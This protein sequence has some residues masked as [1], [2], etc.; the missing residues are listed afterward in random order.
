MPSVLLGFLSLKLTHRMTELR[1]VL[2][3]III[4]TILGAVQ[5]FDNVSHSWLQ[6]VVR[7]IIQIGTTRLMSV[8]CYTAMSKIV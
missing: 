2:A 5:R 4:F 6:R 7:K 1:I 3:Q 8:L